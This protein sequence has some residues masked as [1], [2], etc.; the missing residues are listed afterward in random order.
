[1]G[2]LAKV[3]VQIQCIP[4]HHVYTEESG[5]CALWRQRS[6]DGTLTR[7]LCRDRRQLTKP[8]FRNGVRSNLQAPTSSKSPFGPLVSAARTYITTTTI[9][10]ATSLSENLFRWVTSRQAWWR[11]WEKPSRKVASKLATAWLWKLAS[12]AARVPDVPRG[13]T[14]SA[15][16]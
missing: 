12:L 14:I 6:E 3:H 11:R 16:I 10:M 1:M 2:I 4:T 7:Q 9:E 13:G 5:L 15:R 8:L